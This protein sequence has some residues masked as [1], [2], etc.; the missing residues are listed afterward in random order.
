MPENFSEEFKQKFS[1]ETLCSLFRTD[2]IK[3]LNLEMSDMVQ[4]A[5]RKV[6]FDDQAYN[7][8]ANDSPDS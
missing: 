2:K 4:S 6:S 1:D 8:S 3:E 7:G 5:L